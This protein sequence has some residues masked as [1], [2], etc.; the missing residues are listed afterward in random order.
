MKQASNCCTVSKFLINCICKTYMNG[1]DIANALKAGKAKDEQDWKP[2]P[3]V[4]TKDPVNEKDECEAKT[5]ECTIVCKAEVDS[6]IR[7]KDA[8]SPNMGGAH[9]LICKRCNKA[10]QLK[11]M[12]R[13]DFKRKIKRDPIELPKAIKEHSVSYQ[14]T[15][16]PLSS[17]YDVMRNL[18][19]ICQKDD[20]LLIDYS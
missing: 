10:M 11:L 16:Y 4:S 17:V 12:A 8:H 1:D 7:C 15:K 2:A 9:A 6:W 18:V 20:E 14:E 19:K 5:K 3:M 13:K